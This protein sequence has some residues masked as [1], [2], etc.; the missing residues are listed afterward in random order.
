MSITDPLEQSN[1]L[2]FD[3]DSPDCCHCRKSLSLTP[4]REW[5]SFG[6]I[7]YGCL[8][9]EAE[10]LDRLNDCLVEALRKAQPILDFVNAHHRN[11]QS[12]LAAAECCHMIAL[13]SFG[14][15]KPAEALESSG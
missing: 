5:S 15:T 2:E 9:N 4:G 1:P 12:A 11:T 13:A 7:C 3:S 6:P 8:A 14:K 10:R